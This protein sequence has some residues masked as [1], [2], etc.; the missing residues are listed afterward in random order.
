MLSCEVKSVQGLNPL[1]AHYNDD[2]EWYKID[3]QQGKARELISIQN[4]MKK[5]QPNNF[6]YERS[7]SE[8]VT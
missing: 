6:I 7:D 8:P 2:T 5:Y 4:H 1:N 3:Y